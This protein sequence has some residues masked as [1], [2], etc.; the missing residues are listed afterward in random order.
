MKRCCPYGPAC[1][2]R[3]DVKFGLLER[4][5]QRTVCTYKGTTPYWSVHGVRTLRGATS[6]AF[7]TRPGSR[8]SSRSM[9]NGPPATSRAN[10]RSAPVTAGHLT[11]KD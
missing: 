7:R 10:P 3:G 1:L 4:T 2:P 8:T 9:T 11:R 5:S 6:S